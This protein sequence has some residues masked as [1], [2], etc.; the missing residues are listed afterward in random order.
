MSRGTS[1]RSTRA[2][3]S[4]PVIGVVA[5][6]YAAE[7]FI[8]GCLE[9]LVAATG[10]TLRIVVVD[11]A[12]PDGTVG[13]VEAWASGRRPFVPPRD[14]PLTPGAPVAKP[15]SFRLVDRGAAATTAAEAV[16]TLLRSE[17]NAGFAAG[18][19]AG[20]R[21]LAADRNIDLF[22]ILNPDTVV[23]PQTPAAL[24]RRAED[25][26]RFGVIGGRVL[27]LE[28]PERVQADAGRLHPL[29]YT[30]ISINR[31]AIAVATPMPAADGIDY[32]PGVSML[33]S[34]AFLERAGP[35]DESYFLYFEEIDWQLRCGD[36]PF[37]LEPEARV[38]HRAGASIGSGG[39]RRT[40]SPLSVYFTCRNLLPFVARWSPWRLPFAYGMA[41]IKLARHW[42]TSGR[43]VAAFLA[44]LHRLSPPAAVRAALPDETWAELLA[45]PAD[46][47]A[48]R[49]RPPGR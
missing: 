46:R 8:P 45:P 27:F 25:L 48:V 9:S 37:G 3:A 21:V 49:A 14:W 15:V 12:S 7:R 17:R 42:G 29:S 10:P 43:N 18:V 28:A 40:A 31:G 13:A 19:N 2:P 47:R 11:N 4:S 24:L 20:L 36:L 38:L 5:V 33:V 44:G 35:M 39:W 41:W 22:W 26:G 1:P 34:R 32:V 6:T 16:V 23:E 30:G